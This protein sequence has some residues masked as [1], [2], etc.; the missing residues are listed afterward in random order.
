MVLSRSMMIIAKNT[1]WNLDY[2][3]AS[4]IC[5]EPLHPTPIVWPARLRFSLSS[6]ASARST[7]FFLRDVT[8]A[9]ATVTFCCTDPPC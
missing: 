1:L 4:E 8:V 6:D 3:V 5:F 2:R 7:F 9:R